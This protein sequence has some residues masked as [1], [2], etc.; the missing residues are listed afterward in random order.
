MDNCMPF[1][2]RRI[3]GV[4][5]GVTEM[6]FFGGIMYGFNALYPILKQELIFAYLC[7]NKTS[8]VGCSAQI[9]MYANAFTTYS[10][11]QMV[12][13]I[14]VGLLIDNIGLRIVKIG[15]TLLYFI[16]TLMFAF[17][18]ADV[19][20]LIFPAGCFTCVGGMGMMVCNFSI[21]QLFDATSVLVLA[22]ITGSYDASSSI[23][24]IVSL[25]N[26]AGLSFRTTFIILGVLG[27]AMGLFSATFIL[28]ARMPTMSELKKNSKAVVAET[29]EDSGMESKSSRI[30]LEE[31][32]SHSLDDI[33][34]QEE[35]Q[36]E[37][38]LKIENILQDLH[39]TQRHS[40][41]SL[42]FLLVTAYS[43]C[44]L[45]RFTYFL[46]QLIPQAEDHFQ[47]EV[48]TARIGQILSYVLAGGILA[49]LL[50]GAVI[51][52]LRA[53]FKPQISHLLTYERNE[54]IDNAI[55]WL[56][57][58]PM[59]IS[60]LIMIAFALI[61][62]SLVFINDERVYYAN[63]FFLVFMRGFLFSSVSSSIIAVF[64]VAQFGTLYGI[65]GAI[66]GAF[67][68]LQYALLL[69]TP[70]IGNG[71]ALGIALVMLT[72]P[73]II[74]CKS[75]QTKKKALRGALLAK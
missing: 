23:F 14:V 30:A 69:P 26:D 61:I 19:S 68:S 66:S 29:Y 4:L 50:C 18:S 46:A 9:N 11:L 64:S 52:K 44:A 17:A 70:K 72:P 27:T 36:L 31:N 40:L 35:E 49:G 16:G 10:V 12:M 45:L 32:S 47:D 6:L 25:T 24:A 1:L 37:E 39:P 65:C 3:L 58:L 2:P 7:E 62:S 67:S 71:I 28:T 63:F 73:I 54:D 13:L 42:P 38:D 15:S 75:H 43:C 21:S 56:R 48:I 53:V 34:A 74:I 22:F 41:K 8:T 55:M 59:S 57:L 60:M 20:W 5:F 51:D 33:Q